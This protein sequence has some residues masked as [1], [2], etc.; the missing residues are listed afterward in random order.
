MRSINRQMDHLLGGTRGPIRREYPLLQAWAGEDGL[1][2]MANMP[3]VKQ[4]DLEIGIDGRTLTLSG[5]RP[6]EDRP[7]NARAYRQERANGD[8]N[9][10][11]ELPYDVDVE[12]A[13]ASY[14]DGIM[15]I[16]LP[17]V[18]EDKPRKIAVNGS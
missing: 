6:D 15:R 8:F 7:E 18:A 16:E 1:V 3:G 14:T 17:R 9:R 12:A 11:V 4:E 13:S 10:S 2:I 5:S